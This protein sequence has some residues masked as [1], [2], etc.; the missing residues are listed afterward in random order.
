MKIEKER[1][2]KV[3]AREG[4]GSR[5]EIEQWIQDGRVQVNG[6][7]AELGDRISLHDRVK[8]DRRPVKISKDEIST[9]V[10]MYHKPVGEIC[11]RSDPEGRKTVFES[12]PKIKSARWISV[13][14]LDI[15]TS[16]LLLFT[17]DGELANQL[18]HPSQNIEREY[19]VRILGKVDEALLKRLTQGVQLDDGSARFEHIVYSGGE[20][21]NHWY[22]VVV[23]EGRNRIVRRIWES[24]GVTVSRL[25]R[26]RY[27]PIFLEKSLRPGH[28]QE[29][30][31]KTLKKLVDQPA[32][33]HSD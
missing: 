4:L 33:S 15:N 5:R 19:A 31:E 8:V 13:G 20:G 27:G 32:S 23:V 24:Q 6:R 21:A 12:L 22:H 28:Y 7:V 17:N 26:V 1:L 18:M 30:P 25:M 14:R 16:G 2:Q 3:L 9:R 10:I 11:T 29:V